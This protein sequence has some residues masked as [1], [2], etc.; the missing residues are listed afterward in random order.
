MSRQSPD[1]SSDSAMRLRALARWENEGGTTRSIDLAGAERLLEAQ[2]PPLTTAE[3]IALRVRVIA[4]EN[5]VISLLATAS[6]PQLELAREMTT[7]ISPRSGS[8]PHPLTIHAGE[9]M[10]DLIDR[11]LRF[12]S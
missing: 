12:R 1:M 6:K 5:L 2:I 10:S 8:T 4:L 11:S 7:Y 9:H 3:V